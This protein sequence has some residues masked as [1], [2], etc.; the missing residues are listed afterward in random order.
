MAQTFQFPLHFHLYS[1]CQNYSNG[2]FQNL[3]KYQKIVFQIY[4]HT[5]ACTLKIRCSLPHFEADK[6]EN[7]PD[8]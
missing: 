6:S 2:Q 4:I 5:H 1:I 8:V 7:E 3:A